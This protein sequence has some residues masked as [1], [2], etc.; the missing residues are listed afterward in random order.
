MKRKRKAFGQSVRGASHI[1]QGQPCEDCRKIAWIGENVVIVAAADGHGSSRCPKS[2]NGA[3]I[4]VNT[5]CKIMQEYVEHYQE[6]GEELISYLARE[7]ELQVA[8]QICLEW[9]K[10]V[11]RSYLRSRLDRSISK[12]E[13]L[14]LYGTTLMGAVFAEGFSFFFQIGDGDLM[15]ISIH[16]TNRLLEQETLLG[17]ETH[18][19]GK[20]Q[21]WKKAVSSIYRNQIDIPQLYLMATDGFYNSHLSA[22]EFLY[23][24]RE[25]YEQI[26]ANGMEEISHHL[27]KWL[28]ETSALGCGDDITVMLIS[29]E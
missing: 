8:R 10:R 29:E 25:Y 9:Q 20:E 26:Q 7:G 14:S 21:A 3:R 2:R 27:K 22:E 13:M 23:S 4:A 5:F 15:Q 1:R 24:C 12:A 28:Q 17:V 16:G 19:M 18:S 11:R 6:A